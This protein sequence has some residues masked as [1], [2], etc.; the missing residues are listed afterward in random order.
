MSKKNKVKTGTIL[1]CP[2]INGNVD[3]DSCKEM[4]QDGNEEMQDWLYVVDIEKYYC[5]RCFA[6]ILIESK[7]LFD[8]VQGI[9]NND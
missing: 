4:L 2:D 3:C 6:K 9:Q 8:T 5:S 1:I 7:G